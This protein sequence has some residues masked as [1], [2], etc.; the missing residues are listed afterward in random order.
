MRAA[1][2][3]W[4]QHMRQQDL[5]AVTSVTAYAG[6]LMLVADLLLPPDV[7]SA[8]DVRAVVKHARTRG[9]GDKSVNVLLAALKS[10]YKWCANDSAAIEAL[11]TVRGPKVKANS[12]LP[13]ALTI[14][15]CFELIAAASHRNGWLGKR[16][17]ALLTLMWATGLRVGEALKLT[18]ADAGERRDVVRVWG[19]GNKERLVPVLP[20]AWDAIDAYLV[21]LPTADLADEHPLFVSENLVPL[22]DRDVRRIFASY[23]KRLGLPAD[24]SPHSLRHSFATQLLNAGASLIDIKELLGH[25]S[26]STTA[27]YAHVATDRLMETYEKAHPRAAAVAA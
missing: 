18:I 14:D 9:L 24:A 4:Q 6:Q 12:R 25:E 27:I 19:K 20:A 16:D 15:Q 22:V 13:R 8:K 11:R 2:E 5:L 3:A 1:I 7:M 10:F 21:A 23:A 17:E 26:V